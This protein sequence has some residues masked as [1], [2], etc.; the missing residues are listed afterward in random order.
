MNS[1]ELQ[2]RGYR[3]TTAEILYHMPDH[4]TVLQSYVWQ[5]LDLVPD[6]PILKRFLSFW[7]SR[8]DGRL[9]SVKVASLALVSPTEVRMA[10]E[11][12]LLH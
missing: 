1:L 12:G 7:E 10:T 8:I 4:P 11:I 5:D 9:H 2:L 6:F 3:L